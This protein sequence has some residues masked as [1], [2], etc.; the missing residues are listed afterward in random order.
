MLTESIDQ[1]SRLIASA[2]QYLGL[3][4]RSLARLW[5]IQWLEAGVLW[6]RLHSHI[7]L[8]GSEN[9]SK[10]GFQW[11]GAHLKGLEPI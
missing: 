2:L 8:L 5:W 1:E 10:A 6:K 9:S 11:A 4:V 7:W 3:Q